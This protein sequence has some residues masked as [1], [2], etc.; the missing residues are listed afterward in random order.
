MS[1]FLRFGDV[2]VDIE[3][4]EV[5]T[6]MDTSCGRRIVRPMGGGR[7]TERHPDCIRKATPE[8][9]LQ[10]L[11]RLQDAKAAAGLS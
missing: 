8:E 6:Y 3:T 2:V 1:E 5:L 7:E 11:K 10:A 9:T 4:H